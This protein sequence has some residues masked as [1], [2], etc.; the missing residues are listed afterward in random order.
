MAESWTGGRAGWLLEVQVFQSKSLASSSCCPEGPP[1]PKDGL[2]H[3][4]WN[5]EM[6][7]ALRSSILFSKW[8][9]QIPD[10]IGPWMPCTAGPWCGIQA[11]LPY[12]LRVHP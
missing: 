7:S 5:V 9:N 12:T 11:S 10:K 6:A 4:I 1:Y 2:C 3:T 8:R